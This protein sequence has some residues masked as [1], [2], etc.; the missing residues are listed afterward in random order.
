MRRVGGVLLGLGI[1]L[2]VLGVLAKPV[3]Y[4]RLATVPLDQKSVSI[5]EGAHMSALRAYKADDGLAHYDQLTDVTLRSTRH[6]VGIPGAVP[7]AQ[8]STS[9]FWQTGVLSEA[10]GVAH[11]TYSQ[12]GVSFDRRTAESNNCCGDFR[13][14][15][16]L[17]DPVKTLDVTHEGLF[18]KFP[19]GVEKKTYTWWD[20]DL[21]A[22]A[23]M[24]FIREEELFGTGTYVFEQVTPQTEVD[25]RDVPAAIFGGG[26]GNTDAK[27][28]YGNIRT[29]WVEPNTGTIIKGQ[30]VLDKS[31]VSQLGTVAT[32]KGTIAYTDETVR[33]NASTWGSKG[34]LLGLIGGPLTLIGIILGLIAAGLGAYL[35]AGGRG[36]DE[37]AEERWADDGGGF[38]GVEAL[39]PEEEARPRR[40]A[41]V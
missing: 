14:A 41:G 8:R 28:M 12:E 25:T 2:F 26:A 9:A 39:A 22:A 16:D 18:F 34:K 21:S 11:L 3:L 17:D 33:E 24:K 1:A 35:I 27:V 32:T 19:F 10:V 20:G 29:L 31:L 6:V 4:D 36:T 37:E 40:G 7:E 30:E 15:G 38:D 5:S 23:D 13:S